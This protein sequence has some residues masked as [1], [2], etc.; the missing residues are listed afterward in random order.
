M[1]KDA[2]ILIPPADEQNEIVHYLDEVCAKLDSAIV[3]MEEKISNLK[4]LKTRLVADTVTGKIDVRGI[5]VPDFEYVEETEDI[6]ESEEL[7]E[8]SAE[9]E[10]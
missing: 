9:E 7:D 10:V 8:E 3:K 1:L 4:D 6:S 2:F 5:E